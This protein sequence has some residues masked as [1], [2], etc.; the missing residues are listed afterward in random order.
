MEKLKIAYLIEQIEL[1]KGGEINP[2]SSVQER[3]RMT[4][5]RYTYYEGTTGLQNQR[6]PVFPQGHIRSKLRAMCL[7]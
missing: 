7:L 2:D 1:I 5:L 6:P 4:T 3:Y